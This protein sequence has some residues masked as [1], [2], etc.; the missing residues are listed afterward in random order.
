MV[1]RLH[2][3]IITI[4]IKQVFVILLYLLAVESSPTTRQ[5]HFLHEFVTILI[6]MQSIVIPQITL[7]II[8]G[9]I[10]GQRPVVISVTSDLFVI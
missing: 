9:I 4:T 2:Y 6:F 8:L 10:T 3:I 7:V 5:T 1:T